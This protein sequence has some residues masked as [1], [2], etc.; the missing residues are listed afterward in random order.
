MSSIAS[1]RLLRY[2][3]IAENPYDSPAN[4]SLL[5]AFLLVIQSP[6]HMISC[7]LLFFI[8]HS[9]ELDSIGL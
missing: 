1:I 4:V 3:S 6:P 9:A 2:P 8:N 5:I 7:V